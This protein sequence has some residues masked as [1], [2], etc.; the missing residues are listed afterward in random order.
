MSFDESASHG[1]YCYLGSDVSAVNRPLKYLLSNSRSLPR[2]TA[3]V[4]S[5][6]KTY[7]DLLRSYDKRLIERGTRGIYL[8]SWVHMD[9]E[10]NHLP[11]FVSNYKFP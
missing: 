7:T 11:V 9:K 6:K 4:N 5:N 1:R 8:P 10:E 2:T 3:V